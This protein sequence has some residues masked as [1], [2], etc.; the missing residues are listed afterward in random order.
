MDGQTCRHIRRQTDWQIVDRAVDIANFVYIPF[1]KVEPFVTNVF[2]TMQGTPLTEFVEQHITRCA[3]ASGDGVIDLEV[4]MLRV[5]Y[6]S[7]STAVTVCN[8]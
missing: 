6:I 5:L 7:D 8:K 4:A 2:E 3:A 1:K